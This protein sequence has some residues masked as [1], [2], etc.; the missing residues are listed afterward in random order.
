MVLVL[1]D[2]PDPLPCVSLFTMTDPDFM[3]LADELDSIAEN[4]LKGFPSAAGYV[5]EA[6]CHLREQH[7]I[8]AEHEH[9]GCP[10]AKTGIY[11]PKSEAEIN[12]AAL[13]ILKLP[14]PGGQAM[15]WNPNTSRMEPHSA[16]DDMGMS[17]GTSGD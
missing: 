9:L 2:M 12:E 15:R 1:S 10:T 16:I 13:A 11:A 8:D 4:E 14:I 7:Y 5:K 6:A 3:L 17:K